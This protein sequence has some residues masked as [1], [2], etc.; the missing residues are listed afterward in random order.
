MVNK[1]VYSSTISSRAQKEISESWNW[2]EER[3]QGLGDRFVRAVISRISEI[4][5]H[6]ERYPSRYKTYKETL[7]ESF[8]YL[9]IYKVNKR[10]KIIRVLS[11]FHTSL[12]PGKKYK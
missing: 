11:V 2:Y 12:N 4:E 9:I 6:P 10:K 5:Q 8:P 1:P 7:I 3:Q